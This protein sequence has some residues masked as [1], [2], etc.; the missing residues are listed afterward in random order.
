MPGKARYP[1]SAMPVPDRASAVTRATIWHDVGHCRS[2]LT[3]IA[4][5]KGRLHGCLGLLK[6]RGVEVLGPVLDQA[7]AHSGEGQVAIL[8]GAAIDDIDSD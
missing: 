7:V 5:P 3:A 6:G 1:L 8:V 2:S 4:C